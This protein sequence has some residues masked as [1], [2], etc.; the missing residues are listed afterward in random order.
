[1]LTMDG[2]FHSRRAQILAK[3]VHSKRI[4][5][6]EKSLLKPQITE[7]APYKHRTTTVQAPNKHRTVR[8]F[9]GPM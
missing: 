4:A 5:P 3:N 1:M 7:H 6:Y 9:L 2:S 8:C